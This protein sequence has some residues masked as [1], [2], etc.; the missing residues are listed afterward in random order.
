[1]RLFTDD[2]LHTHTLRRRRFRALKNLQPFTTSIST[3]IDLG[4]LGKVNFSP[5]QFPIKTLCLSPSI[6]LGLFN[7][8]Q[9]LHL[10]LS[11][12][13]VKIIQNINYLILNLLSRGKDRPN[14][15]FSH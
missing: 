8:K 11:Q 4:V 13:T 1:M 5:G 6:A 15:Y 7:T 12:H 2:Y 9:T 14:I 3:A 10:R